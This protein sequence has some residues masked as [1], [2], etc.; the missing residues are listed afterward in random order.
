[1]IVWLKCIVELLCQALDQARI[2]IQTLLTQTSS[3]GDRHDL[4]SKHTEVTNA[5]LEQL[6]SSLRQKESSETAIY[7]ETRSQLVNIE[8][9]LSTITAATW[10]Q[11]A[12]TDSKV[13]TQEDLS[14]IH[15]VS[16]TDRMESLANRV[17]FSD[18][19]RCARANRRT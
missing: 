17:Y 15:T 4:V 9:V 6:Y 7:A 1:M 12:F 18:S 2:D 10:L 8:R 5:R 16:R 11:Q 3:H 13:T 14:Q 19:P